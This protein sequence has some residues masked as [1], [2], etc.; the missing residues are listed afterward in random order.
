M[1]D[2]GVLDFVRESLLPAPLR[3]LEV[4]AGSGE[5]AAAL[6]SAG[7]EVVPIDPASTGDPVRPIPLH[8][9]PER[10]ESFDAAV[11]VVSLHHVEPLRES[12]RRLAQV[13]RP[14]GTLVLDE[15]DCARFD[16]RAARWWLEHRDADEHEHGGHE[17]GGH[18]QAGHEP[19]T[20]EEIVDF[21]RHHI[22]DLATLE[23]T[24]GEWFELGPPLRGPY[25]YRWELP[26]GL[27]LTEEEDIAA[28]RLPAVGV[29]IVGTR[30][31]RPA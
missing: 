24:L 14:G 2:P 26:P 11:A 17:H 27:R 30:R 8:D 10:P 29:R 12:C 5:L 4:G 15:I 20:P 13:V 22:H 6:V 18:E 25:L 16:E 1:L 21:L 31:P 9:L 23:D 3:V 19:G 28:G 7:Y